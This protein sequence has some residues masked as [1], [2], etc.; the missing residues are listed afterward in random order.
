M[1]LPEISTADL[2]LVLKLL[3]VRDIIFRS[4]KAAMNT[5]VANLASLLGFDKPILSALANIITADADKADAELGLSIHEIYKRKMNAQSGVNANMAEFARYINA[6]LSNV[7]S[8]E[9]VV[10]MLS[11]VL[12]MPKSIVAAYLTPYLSEASIVT[13]N[14][15]CY[16]FDVARLNDYQFETRKLK[17]KNQN[18]S[19]SRL[20]FVMANLYVGYVPD[21]KEV[22]TV[23]GI[24]GRLGQILSSLCSASQHKRIESMLQLL[25]D[26]LEEQGLP[27]RVTETLLAL[28]VFLK[29]V[30]GQFMFKFKED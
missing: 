3:S 20:K 5:A 9:K 25:R 8:S 18:I 11:G 26:L 21:I 4:N 2:E 6:E 16:L 7:R 15:I 10:D 28:F 23:F 13:V 27:L 24:E 29:G 14:D 22:E 12:G 1:D 19:L 30:P 17:L